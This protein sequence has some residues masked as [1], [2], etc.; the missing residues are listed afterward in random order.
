L[1][2]VEM[3]TEPKVFKVRQVRGKDPKIFPGVALSFFTEGSDLVPVTQDVI[4]SGST[5]RGRSYWDIIVQ[6][7]RVWSEPGDDG[8]SRASFPVALMHS[9]EG[10]THN[11]V[12]TFL[13][14]GR[15]LTSLQFQV[16][17][18]TSPYYIE[19]YFT[20]W[21]RAPV[22]FTEL[23]ETETAFTRALPASPCPSGGDLPLERA[24]EEGRQ[25]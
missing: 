1:S 14:K 23:A 22:R 15:E 7:G 25:G 20:A 16:V 4:R 5:T 13:Y 12:A 24:G 18:Q 11:G 19:D 10:E 8:W 6:P 17:Q 2:E 21:R 3:T 9:I